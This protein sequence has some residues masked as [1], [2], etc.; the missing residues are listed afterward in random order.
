VLVV[1][2]LHVPVSV[3]HVTVSADVPCDWSCDKGC[4]ETMA[5]IQEVTNQSRQGMCS[6]KDWLHNIK[7][8]TTALDLGI[9]FPIFL[10]TEGT[11]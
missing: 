8:T 1:C 9:I 4:G 5:V 11:F 3:C 2:N 6:I 10:K 7:F